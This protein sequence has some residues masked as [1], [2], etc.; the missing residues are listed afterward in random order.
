[1]KVGIYYGSTIGDTASIAEKLGGFFNVEAVSI[2]EG[3]TNIDNFD[4]ILLGSSTWGY[5]D[6]QDEWNDEIE[7]LKKMNLAGKKVGLFGTGDQESY[8]DTFC[9]AL[10]IIGEAVREAGG[11]IIGFTSRD[12]YNFD[13]S[14]ALEDNNLMGLAIDVNNQD[15]MTS[16]RIENWVEQLKKEM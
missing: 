10:G 14:K 12:S 1:M 13:D 2:S 11:E 5:G 4:L 9:D 8:V 7:S 3:L 6:L 16:S 15:D